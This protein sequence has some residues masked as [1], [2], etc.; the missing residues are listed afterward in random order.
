MS[1][2]YLAIRSVQAEINESQNHS[3]QQFRTGPFIE[4]HWLK[5]SKR[6]RKLNT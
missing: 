1:K 2:S 5:K 6:E 4:I 3:S